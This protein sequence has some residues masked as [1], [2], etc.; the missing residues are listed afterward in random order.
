MFNNFYNKSLLEKR[1]TVAS[2]IMPGNTREEVERRVFDR[3]RELNEERTMHYY[4]SSYDFHANEEDMIRQWGDILNYLYESVYQT[5]VIKISTLIEITKFK[6]R[7][8]I[9]LNNI[10]LEL[11][12]RGEYMLS[13]QLEGDEYFRT[14]Y[15][16]LY[17]DNTWGKWVTSG[18]IST[19]K[20]PFQLFYSGEKKVELKP[21]DLLI[22]KKYF[23]AQLEN[24][25]NILNKILLEEDIEVLT[26]YELS[27]LLDN[28]GFKMKDS[29]LD[30]SL[31]YLKKIKKIAIFKVKVNNTEI[32]C[33]KLLKD[34]SSEVT[35]KDK[36]I[37]NILIQIKNFDRKL[38]EMMNTAQSCLLKAKD[39]LKVKN[40]DAATNMMKRKNVYLRA[41]QHYS[42]LKF[43]LEQNLIDIKSMESNQNVK[44]ILEDVAK[45]SEK[46]ILNVDEMDSIT[47]KLR[48]KQDHIKEAGNILADFNNDNLNVRIN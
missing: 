16:N 19:V 22:N 25:L 12:K 46:L 14:N 31:N 8:P 48:N 43:T 5:F 17:K 45:T 20:I 44:Y 6:N 13:S 23:H 33:V 42:N 36:A 32:E 1:E 47:D 2:A 30:I 38:D 40:R 28:S 18:I 15:K 4:F 3:F 39:Y 41:Y 24:I 34:P 11:I 37:I 26:K 9:G 35:E 21:D 29:Y 27:L 10:I 7:R